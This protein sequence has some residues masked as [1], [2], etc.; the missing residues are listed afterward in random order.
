MPSPSVSFEDWRR[1]LAEDSTPPSQMSGVD[2]IR[3]SSALDDLLAKHAGE[4]EDGSAVLHL[5]LPAATGG[6]L[7]QTGSHQ[8]RVTLLFSAEQ[9]LPAQRLVCIDYL[10]RREARVLTYLAYPSD[11]AAASS[12][13]YVRRSSAASIVLNQNEHLI[14]G[15]AHLDDGVRRAWLLVQDILELEVQVALSVESRAEEH[16]RTMRGKTGPALYEEV[17]R[18][19]ANVP[20]T[21]C[22]K[23][24]IANV[25][26]LSLTIPG[27]EAGPPKF[28]VDRQLFGAVLL[29]LHVGASTPLDAA[30]WAGL[31][32]QTQAL[33]PLHVGASTPLDA[34]NW[35]GLLPR[36]QALLPLHVALTT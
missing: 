16:E 7:E 22:Q 25:I 36:T 8:D 32:P 27:A 15:C 3:A 13:A 33:L 26:A 14:T 19:L 12:E 30:N 20:T 28:L 10:T 24:T 1:Q 9:G 17:R 31:L 4:V 18:R 23:T 11:D 29:P 5:P 34:A 2:L 35:A 21:D 6:E